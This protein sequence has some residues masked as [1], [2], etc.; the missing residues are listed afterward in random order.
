MKRDTVEI[1]VWLLRKGLTQADV[2]R[3]LGVSLSLVSHYLAGRRHSRRIRGYF[4][5]LG[6]PGELLG[7]EEDGV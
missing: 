3:D 5:S 2:A 1:K 4:L 6:C 7:V